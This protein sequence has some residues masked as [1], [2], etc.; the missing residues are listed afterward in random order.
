MKLREI[1]NGITDMGGQIRAKSLEL[2]RLASDPEAS[3][4]A[5]QTAKA[6]MKAL[7]ERQNALKASYQAEEAAAKAGAFVSIEN[8]K[9]TTNKEE[10]KMSEIRKSNEYARAFAF[11]M[12]NG[13]GVK[14]GR[15]LEETKILYDALTEGGGTTPGEDGGFLVPEDMEHE[16]KELKRQLNPLSALFGY[17]NVNTNTGWRVVDTA[18]T[19]GM[20]LVN[21]MATIPT[22]DQPAFVKVPFTLA[23]YAL[24]VPVSNELLSDEV[25][26]LMSYLARW[27][28]RKQVITENGLLIAAL[29]TLTASSIV[30]S[31]TGKTAIDGVKTALNKT[32]DPAISLSSIILCSQSAFDG[33]D[34]I[35][36]DTGRGLLQ[37]DP[38][39][40][41]QFRILGRPVHVVADAWLP[42]GT[43]TG[44]PAEIFIGDGKEFAT[45]FQK[46]GFEIAS[47]N[48]GGNAWA[49]DSTE[50]RGISRMCVSKFDAAAMVRRS[51]ALA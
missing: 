44:T 16:I 40:A 27:F 22:D 34:Q 8:N 17:E 36:D 15:G 7:Q 30:P 19:S 21:E 42:N 2:S 9:A 11:A 41:T 45:L 50:V 18:P 39:N 1:M 13:I 49:T 12:R 4:E 46:D 10:K 3:L 35:V 51:L 26:N 14:N 31:G 47:T 33:L 28:A 37:P 6:E 32:L 48:I 25:A 20:T 38:A 23:K 29:K 24:R 5:I 43:G